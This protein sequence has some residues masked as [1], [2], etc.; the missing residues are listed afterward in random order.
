MTAGG[1]REAGRSP[2]ARGNWGSVACGTS[3]LA[4]TQRI[5]EPLLTLS[6]VDPWD[7]KVRDARLLCPQHGLPAGEEYRVHIMSGA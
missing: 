6:Q 1:R 7:C 5:N 3:F 2:A 4:G